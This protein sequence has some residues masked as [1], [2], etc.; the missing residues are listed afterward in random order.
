M[1][2]IAAEP[3]QPTSASSCFA[4][5]SARH[6]RCGLGARE[7]AQHGSGPKAGC[8][9]GR[10]PASRAVNEKFRATEGNSR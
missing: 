6:R 5:V 2:T 7:L 4:R 8:D 1:F 10:H 3:P 9:H